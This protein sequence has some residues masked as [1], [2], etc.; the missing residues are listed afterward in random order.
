MNVWKTSFEQLSIQRLRSPATAHPT[1]TP[2][3]PLLVNKVK[4]WSVANQD[5][6]KSKRHLVWVRRKQAC[7]TFH[8]RS[9]F[10][11]FVTTWQATWP[12]HICK[13]SQWTSSSK[14]KTESIACSKPILL[15]RSSQCP[16]AASF[17]AAGLVGCPTVS[18]KS[19]EAFSTRTVRDGLHQKKQRV[20]VVGGGLTAVQAASRVAE[21]GDP[22][23]LCSRRPLCEK[24]FDV[25]VEWFDQR[26]ADKRLSGFCHDAVERKL[27]RLKEARDGGSVPLM[28][29]KELQENKGCLACWVG[30]IQCHH[31]EEDASEDGS[32][33]MLGALMRRVICFS[34]SG[35]LCQHATPCVL[36]PAAKKMTPPWPDKSFNL[37]RHAAVRHVTFSPSGS[38]LA[39]CINCHNAEKHVNHVW[40]RW[41]NKET[42]LEG[43]TKHVCC[44]EHSL[45]G[46]HMASGSEAGSI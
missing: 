10:Q 21:A 3:W 45:D 20:L 25:P 7:G 17:F 12:T 11:I 35:L 38:Q 15:E 27:E 44:L 24:R 8:Q 36:C 43:H 31:E 14:T 32:V 34:H 28:H 46:Q 1:E 19:P 22:C 18:W 23:V 29:M 2:S 33:T 26:K 39:F 16:P 6:L 4:S 5:A 37:L 13:D 9:C 41:C 30:D 40:D 42:L